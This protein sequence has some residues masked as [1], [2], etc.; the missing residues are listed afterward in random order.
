MCR[1]PH[2][3]RGLKF[4]A[5]VKIAFPKGRTPHGVRGLK[6]AVLPRA[7]E[8]AQ[9]HPAWGAWIEIRDPAQSYAQG[10]GRTP[11]GVRGLKLFVCFYYLSSHLSHPAWGAWIEICRR[12]QPRELHGV[13]PRMGCVD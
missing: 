11:H 6:C 2:G 13:A 10:P 3:V 12:R 9:S 5:P 7:R 1:T 8:K 4:A